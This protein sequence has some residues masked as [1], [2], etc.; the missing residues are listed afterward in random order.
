MQCTSR[1]AAAASASS[2]TIFNTGV[3]NFGNLLAPAA[4]DAHWS[5]S[6][7]GAGNGTATVLDSSNGAMGWAWVNN[8]SNAQWV[9]TA[10]TINTGTPGL[11]TYSQNFSLSGFNAATASISGMSSAD[12]GLVDIVLNGHSMGTDGAGGGGIYGQ[13]G[14]WHNFSLNSGFVSGMNTISF[15]TYNQDDNY[16]GLIVDMRGCAQAVPEPAP[17]AC[18]GLGLVGILAR[19]KRK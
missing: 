9:S 16:E 7:N 1:F 3:D 5:V 15:V 17:V 19:R 10:N 12:D 4:Q 13:W 11:Y 8:T 14:S 2:F 6:P 18:L